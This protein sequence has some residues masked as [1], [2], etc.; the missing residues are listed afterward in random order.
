MSCALF[1]FLATGLLSNMAFGVQTE[2]SITAQFIEHNIGTV[3][4]FSVLSHY[5]DL[6]DRVLFSLS[7]LPRA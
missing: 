3:L 6:S 7:W 1:L 5:S 4:K 2:V